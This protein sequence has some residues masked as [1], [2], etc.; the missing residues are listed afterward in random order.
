[1]NYVKAPKN[2][3]GMINSIGYSEQDCA[4]VKY[5]F[6]YLENGFSEISFESENDFCIVLSN[7]ERIRVQVKINQFTLEFV[8]ELL[9]NNDIKDKTIFVGTGY[10]DDFRVLLQDKKR[11]QAAQEGVLCDDKEKLYKE[12]DEC[13]KKKHVN[14]DSFLQCEFMILDGI[15]REAIAMSAIDAWARN[16]RIFVDTEQLFNEL[17]A[18]ISNRLRTFG[19]HLSKRDVEEI[20]RKHRN[21]KIESFLPKKDRISSVIEEVCKKGLAEYIDD[22]IKRYA[23]LSESLLLIKYNLLNEQLIETRNRIEEILHMCPEL[24]GILLMV[25]NILGEYDAVIEWE[26]ED[27][28]DDVDCIVEY[29]KAYMYKGDFEESQKYLE[30]I[31]EK[32]WEPLVLYISAKNH[33]GMG[34]IEIARR[35]LEQCIAQNSEY[36]DAYVFLASLIYV[37]ETELA[38]EYL[39]KAL[40]VDPQCAKA[41]L[42]RA[43]ISMLSDD[44]SCVIENCEKYIKCSGDDENDSVLLTLA[45]NKFHIETDDWQL[46]FEKW[47]NAYRKNNKI[48]GESKVPVMDLGMS[49]SCFFV[50]HSMEEGLTV[51]CGG[52]EIFSYRSKHLVRTA[53]GLYSPSIDF[54][55]KKF[56]SQDAANPIRKSPKSIFQEVALPTI[57]R[58]YG[59]LKSYEYALNS[60]LEQ[61]VLHLNHVFGEHAKEYTIEAKDISVKMEVI[62][63]KLIGNAIIGQLVLKIE[64]NPLTNSL[65]MFI[66]QLNKKCSYNEAAIILAYDDQHQT[67]LTFPKEKMTLTL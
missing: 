34:Q 46:A 18:L 10:D 22:L 54:E 29:A 2:V 26:Q 48:T 62:G 61:N 13:C 8:S 23:R 57:F 24:K 49:Y 47:N 55:M 44:F 36:V 9:K 3:G 42:L 20:V 5:M 6:D 52:K 50:L 30:T 28:K 60:L 1:M 53:I 58:I 31:D 64:I 12:I 25:L 19:G 33:Q 39:D 38:V 43:K 21:S 67:Q 65:D 37:S 56:V 41:Y 4:S 63:N 45:L 7:G 17:I 35:E 66:E 40:D 16:R 27:E 11:Y 59:D 51:F 32:Y 15:N 14:T